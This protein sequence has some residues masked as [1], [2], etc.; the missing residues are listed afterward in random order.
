MNHY[1][2][3]NCLDIQLKLNEYKGVDDEKKNN[4][5]ASSHSLLTNIG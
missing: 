5:S 4:H 2:I 3:F 1:C